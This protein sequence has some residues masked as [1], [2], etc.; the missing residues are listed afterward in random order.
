MDLYKYQ[1][2]PQ[3]INNEQLSKRM[4]IG[5]AK[6]RRVARCMTSAS[7][8]IWLM[9]LPLRSQLNHSRR[10]LSNLLRRT[11]THTS[12]IFTLLC[13]GMP[14][15]EIKSTRQ[16]PHSLSCLRLTMVSYFSITSRSWSIPQTCRLHH[17]LSGVH[18]LKKTI[19]IQTKTFITTRGQWP[20]WGEER[21]LTSTKRHLSKEMIQHKPAA[22]N[23]SNWRRRSFTLTST[24]IRI[25]MKMK[26]KR[27]G[28]KSRKIST[29]KDL[30]LASRTQ[31]TK[32]PKFRR[33]RVYRGASTLWTR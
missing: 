2:C 14:P 27:N 9:F 12:R 16:R 28:A 31:T 30:R 26:C 4:T 22:R 11:K 7:Q 8:K 24:L 33:K 3:V 25:Q 17:H 18:C 13:R 19:T 21:P 1:L 10:K 6:V 29:S 32:K 20:N 5:T 15:S 23:V